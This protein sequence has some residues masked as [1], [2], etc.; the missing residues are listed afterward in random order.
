MKLQEMSLREIRR[1]DLSRKI[2]RNELAEI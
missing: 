1:N 2:S